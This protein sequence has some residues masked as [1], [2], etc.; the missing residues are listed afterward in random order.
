MAATGATET[1]APAPFRSATAGLQ[2]YNAGLSAD[3]VRRRY[4]I[5]DVIK[6]ASNENPFGP[7]PA[8]S[9]AVATA[10]GAVAVYPDPYCS[11]LRL[12]IAGRLGVAPDRL[13]FGNGSEDLIGIACR[14]FLDPGDR[15]VLS[16]PTFSVYADFAAV[17]GAAVVDVPRRADFSLDAAA[18][19]AALRAPTK[20]LFLCNPNN[21]T[22]TMIP[23]DHFE[24]IC[25]AAGTG[26]LIIADEAYCEYARIEP[27]YPGSLDFLPGIAAPWLVL[28]TFSK[29]YGLAGLRIGYGIASSPEIARQIDMVRTAFNVNHLAQAAA[30]AAFGDDA[31][32][33]RTVAHNAAERRRVAGLLR[34]RGLDPAASATN[35]LYLDVGRDA[36]RTAEALLA[37]GIIVKPWAGAFARYIRVSIGTVAENDR[38]L[39]A[40]DRVLGSA[41]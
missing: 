39:A 8:A 18:V 14:A 26:T 12:E 17:M 28:R 5:A 20:L 7:S 21:P 1:S 4:G 38:F 35:F 22:G 31:H 9:A 41:G 13:V 11:A 34:A 33:E 30:L 23:R 2:P 37:H 10:L 19:R 24:A 27:D 25:R 6:L 3:H 16:S 15:A 32:V 29:A 36:R 40:L